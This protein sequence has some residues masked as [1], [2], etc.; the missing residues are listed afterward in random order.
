[1]FQ[2]FTICCTNFYFFG[3]CSS[4]SNLLPL[5]LPLPLT[6]YLVLVSP[7]CAC[8]IVTMEWC[9]TVFPP[10]IVF[11]FWIICLLI[12]Y[13]TPPTFLIGWHVATETFHLPHSS[14]YKPHIGSAGFLVDSRP[15]K[16]EPI[17]CPEMSVRNYC[18]SLCSNL[19]GR[20]S[21]LL[22][23]RSLKSR[24]N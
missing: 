16:M 8:R 22:R 2:F 13:C 18:C 1:M 7:G 21:H 5:T 11:L 6:P 17:D 24:L 4:S 15:L 19:E 10:P 20:S 23:S 9:W 3:L 14:L 12:K